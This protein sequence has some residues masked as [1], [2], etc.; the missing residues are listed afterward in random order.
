M[1]GCEIA[2]SPGSTRVAEFMARLRFLSRIHID[3]NEKIDDS[4][5]TVSDNNRLAEEA[6]CFVPGDNCVLTRRQIRDSELAGTIRP[7]VPM[8]GSYDD[9]RGHVGMQVAVDIDNT[10]FREHHFASFALVVAA[11][12]ECLRF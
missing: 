6:R 8:I 11:K 4:V 5:V 7:C 2:L 9:G 3:G 10:G 1:R 12:I